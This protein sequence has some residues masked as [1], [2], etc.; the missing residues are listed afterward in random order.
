MLNI[1]FTGVKLMQNICKSDMDVATDL[2]TVDWLGT[3]GVERKPLP[4]GGKMAAENSS[5]ARLFSWKFATDGSAVNV[6]IPSQA[7]N[8]LY[9]FSV[10]G[11][12]IY[13]YNLSLGGV[14]DDLSVVY[15]GLSVMQQEIL[16]SATVFSSFLCGPF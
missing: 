6:V 9:V 12:L 16:S 1:Q 11:G 5:I 13:G 2:L 8:I 15:G 7:Q 10:I 4:Q 14:L 3:W